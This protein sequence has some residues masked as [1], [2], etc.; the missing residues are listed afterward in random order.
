MLSRNSGYP[1]LNRAAFGIFGAWWPAFNQA[2][3]SIVRTESMKHH[4]DAFTILHT[5]DSIPNDAS[6][7]NVMARGSALNL[8]GMLELGIFWLFTCCFLTIPVP[9]MKVLVH[10]KLAV[11]VI[12][13]IAICAWTLSIASGI[14]LIAHQP[15][16]PNGSDY[17]RKP[18]DVILGDLLDFPISNVCLLP[19]SS[20][21]L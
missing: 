4:M 1:I 3:M 9:K 16:D 7:K 15:G 2:V 18:N 14:G 10:V 13:T 8:V 6:F 21:S 19:R 17:A 5:I 12:S 20:A 11:F